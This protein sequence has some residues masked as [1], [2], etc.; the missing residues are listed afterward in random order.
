MKLRSFLAT[1][2]LA[3]ASTA[4]FVPAAAQEVPPAMLVLDASGS[5]LNDDAGGQTRIAAAQEA[6]S[7]F[8]EEA[9]PR[10]N[11]GLVTY[12]GNTGESLDD[13]E[14]GCRDVT[15]VTSPGTGTASEI[16][17]HVDGLSPSGFTPIGL[18][19]Q[20]AASELD[21]GGT[22]VLVSDGVD[23]CAPPPVCEVAE[24]LKA[25][26]V[27]IIVNTVGF[28]VDEEARAELECIAGA[29]GGRYAPATDASSLAAELSR[30]TFRSFEG[31][32]STLE[33]IEGSTEE[34]PTALRRGQ[35]SFVATLTPPGEGSQDR[36]TT[37]F[38]TPVSEGERVVISAA[39][40][41]AP[42]GETSGGHFPLRIGVVDGSPRGCLLDTSTQQ[43]G[44]SSSFSAGAS[45]WHPVGPECETDELVFGIQRSGNELADSDV[46][47]EVVI[48]RFGATSELPSPES[49]KEAPEASAPQRDDAQVTEAGRWFDSATPLTPGQ[50]IET[51]IVP[52]ETHFFA[53]DASY[54]QQVSYAGQLVDEAN[55]FDTP[56][57]AALNF[58]AFNE[59]RTP[60]RLS[61]VNTSIFRDR[62]FT[63]GY[64]API[65]FA[66]RYGGADNEGS[67]SNDVTSYW[68]DGTQ[69]LVVTYEHILASNSTD[70]TAEL[71]AL[72]YTLVADVTGDAASGP[73]FASLPSADETQAES[74]SSS[75]S[76]DNDSNDA[77]E[78]AG[79]E[80]SSESSPLIYVGI[81]VLAILI[82][83]V[84]VGIR[85]N[86]N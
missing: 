54:G 71:P 27:D 72:T 9:G 16:Q 5:M 37:W 13:R 64:S 70:T 41:T 29:T 58:D 39:S 23:T 80:D 35:D 42:D 38:S 84:L 36:S 40:A 75:D 45:Y 20:E 77:T 55:N 78:A 56:M 7:R 47:A 68:L 33:R 28:R 14:E 3:S 63:T 10:A 66:N 44:R 8:L 73:D 60:M 11:L 82:I 59:A 46:D 18:A 52:G 51:D 65:N 83:G 61:G 31:H 50:A 1:T 25:Q 48:S 81:A 85:R 57:G 24:E 17:Q 32:Q 26:N 4:A 22:V 74:A 79:N 76:A 2:I 19:L 67:D 69:Y 86:K 12:G 30:A 34:N 21:G 43:A 62:E 53:V 15:V 49:E 6:T